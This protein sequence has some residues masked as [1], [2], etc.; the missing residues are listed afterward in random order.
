MN[1]LPSP[2]ASCGVSAGCAVK[3]TH[4]GGEQTRE[5]ETRGQVLAR[6][7]LDTA[8]FGLIVGLYRATRR[9]ADGSETQPMHGHQDRVQRSVNPLH[10]G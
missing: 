6:V 5:A 8:V 1:M 7:G 3:A 4:P 10:H 2:G 9:R